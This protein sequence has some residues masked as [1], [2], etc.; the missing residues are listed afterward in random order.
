MRPGA[1]RDSAVTSATGDAWR[2]AIDPTATAQP[3]IVPAGAAATISVVIT[4]SAPSGAVVSGDLFV[5]DTTVISPFGT[6]VGPTGD[7]LAAVPYRYTV[8]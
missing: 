8:N 1:A 7:E 6:P 5:D 4:P 2:R 3:V